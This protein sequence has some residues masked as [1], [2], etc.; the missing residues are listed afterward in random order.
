MFLTALCR[1][2][3]NLALPTVRGLD[4][5]GFGL[6]KTWTTAGERWKCL[7]G[8]LIALASW[9]P[10]HPPWDVN[11]PFPFPSDQGG[12]DKTNCRPVIL[13]TQGPVSQKTALTSWVS[14]VSPKPKPVYFN[15]D[16]SSGKRSRV[17]LD[18]AAAILS[19][20]LP[21]GRSLRLEAVRCGVVC[22]FNRVKTATHYY[23]EKSAPTC[24]RRF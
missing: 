20:R 2:G 12:H 4:H 22:Y 1:G 6:D 9:N 13:S 17:L 19:G 21:E 15:S 7:F 14:F 3:C 18:S 10:F 5:L 16:R 11:C 24:K 23:T 8:L